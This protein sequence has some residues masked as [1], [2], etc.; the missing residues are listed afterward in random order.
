MSLYEQI[1]YL[2]ANIVLVPFFTLNYFRFECLNYL[3][4]TKIND[5]KKGEKTLVGA[6]EI[7]WTFFRAQP[8]FQTKKRGSTSM[9]LILPI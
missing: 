5:V 4:K 8:D 2:L 9:L 1:I 3:D 6:Y 7:F